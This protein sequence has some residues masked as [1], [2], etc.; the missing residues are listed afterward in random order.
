MKEEESWEKEERERLK[1]DIDL[2]IIKA[3]II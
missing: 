3:G 2:G 1:E